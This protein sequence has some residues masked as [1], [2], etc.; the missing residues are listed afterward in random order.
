MTTET[1]TPLVEAIAT[2]AEVAIARARHCEG[3]DDE[4]EIDE[5]AK[6]S[7][8]EDGT[9]VQAWVFVPIEV[10]EPETKD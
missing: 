3:S 4:I 10:L 7:R 9:W 8:G 5:P 1:E 6:A 2:D